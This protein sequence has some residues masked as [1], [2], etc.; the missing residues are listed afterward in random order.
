MMT[1]SIFKP[2]LL[3]SMTSLSVYLMMFGSPIPAPN[4]FSRTSSVAVV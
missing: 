2:L 4:P 3:E 1:I